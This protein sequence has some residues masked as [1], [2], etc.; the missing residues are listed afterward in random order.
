M[1][2]AIVAHDE[3]KLIGNNNC[4][5]WHNTDDLA[6]FKSV[7]MNNT[8]LMGRKTFESIGKVLPGRKSIVLTRD[9]NYSID[10]PDVLVCH[11]LNEILK[12][13]QENGIDLFVI[14][15][16]SI[17]E[18][19]LPYIEELHIS[20]IEGKYEGDTHFCEYEDDYSLISSKPMNGFKLKI[21]TRKENDY[22]ND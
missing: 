21:Y 5:P 3:N 8:I 14:G 7:T 16:A 9:L 12:D 1:I 2:K 19:S 4:L 10:H 13:F 11:D 17:Y 18:Q 20:L 6:Y 22:E 15:G